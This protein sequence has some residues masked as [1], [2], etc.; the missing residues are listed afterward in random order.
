[1]SIFDIMTNFIFFSICPPPFSEGFGVL[2]KKRLPI[3]EQP[4]FNSPLTI[5]H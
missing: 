1:M 4:L 5:N 3:Y 2:N